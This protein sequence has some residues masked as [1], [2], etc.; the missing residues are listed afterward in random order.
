MEAMHAHYLEGADALP[1]LT[2]QLFDRFDAHCTFEELYARLEFMVVQCGHLCCYLHRWLRG[3][4][5]QPQPDHRSILLELAH[6]LQC[7]AKV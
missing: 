1:T 3:R 4:L 5:A 7:Y 6:M 2:R